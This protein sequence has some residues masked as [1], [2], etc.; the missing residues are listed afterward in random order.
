LTFPSGYL[1]VQGIQLLTPQGA[2]ALEPLIDLVQRLGPQTVD[3]PLGVLANL[4]E[5]GLTEHS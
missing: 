3:A 4:D 5:P 1:G 2:V